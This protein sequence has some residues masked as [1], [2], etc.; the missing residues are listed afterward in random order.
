MASLST[1]GLQATFPANFRA[2]AA[3]APISPASSSSAAAAAGGAASVRPTPLPLASL[4]PTQIP[5]FPYHEL[6]YETLKDLLNHI[7]SMH[8]DAEKIADAI[9]AHHSSIAYDTISHARR[10]STTSTALLLHDLKRINYWL[11]N[12][13]QNRK[14]LRSGAQHMGFLTSSQLE[15]FNEAK[16]LIIA[17]LKTERHA[18]REGGAFLDDEEAVEGF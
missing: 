14:S 4:A 18:L 6:G 2:A 12:D 16:A 15:M 1:S 13:A 17:E 7:N 9:Q 8:E 5:A 11:K 3:M 10:A